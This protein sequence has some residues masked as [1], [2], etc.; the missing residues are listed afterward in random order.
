MV[1]I[2]ELQISIQALND[3]F[4]VMLDH[5]TKAAVPNPLILYWVTTDE[6][7]LS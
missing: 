1:T 2:K 4:Q 7:I 3:K 5:P 6:A